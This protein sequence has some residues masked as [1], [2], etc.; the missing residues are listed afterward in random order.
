MATALLIVA[1]MVGW[2]YSGG[3][4]TLSLFLIVDEIVLSLFLAPGHGVFG[5][6]PGPS[7]RPWTGT[8]RILHLGRLGLLTAGLVL[9]GMALMTKDDRAAAGLGSGGLLAV[10]FVVVLAGEVVGRFLFYGLIARPGR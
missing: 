8:P 9:V 7:L 5:H 6:R 2:S 3:L 10:A 1:R 4:L